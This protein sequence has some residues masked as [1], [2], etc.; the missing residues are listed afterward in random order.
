MMENAKQEVPGQ[1]TGRRERRRAETFERIRAAAI[2]LFNTRG[3]EETTVEDIT[4]AADIGKGTFFNYFPSKDALLM[5]VFD[6]VRQEF[7]NLQTRVSAATN[8]RQALRDFAHSFIRGHIRAPR[9]IRSIFGQAL[10]DPVMGPRFEAL[11]LAAR[12]TVSTLLQ[13]GQKM[14]QIRTDIPAEVLGRTLQQFIFGTEIMWSFSTGEDLL[15]WI[16]V[17]FEIFF[18]GAGAPQHGTR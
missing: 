2:T 18:T 3:F 6:S 7:A 13:H 14:G 17:M 5:A 1:E 9:I 15:E 4:E 12:Q 16:D 8:V 10:T 11:V